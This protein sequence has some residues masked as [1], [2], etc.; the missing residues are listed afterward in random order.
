MNAQFVLPA[1]DESH[2]IAN[3][4]TFLGKIGLLLQH[5][6]AEKSVIIKVSAEDHTVSVGNSITIVK[7]RPVTVKVS[8]NFNVAI[9]INNDNNEQTNNEWKDKSPWL[10]INT[11][12][13]FGLKIKFYKK[14]LDMFL[15][16]TGMLT[17][18]AHGLIG[19]TIS[20]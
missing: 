18:E 4:S 15:M 14:H 8:S 19:N 12:F 1:E 10:Y 20:A 13:N 6:I 17:R 2:T 5:P 11:D 9:N 16:K 7:N 3:V